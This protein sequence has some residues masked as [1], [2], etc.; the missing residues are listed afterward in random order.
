[1]EPF[2]TILYAVQ[3]DVLNLSLP[4]PD[5]VMEQAQDLVELVFESM[6]EGPNDVVLDL[7]GVGYINSSGISVI[8]RLNLE[9]NLRLVNPS[10]MVSEI[11]ELTGVLPF[12]PRFGSL[13]EAIASF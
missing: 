11:L 7:S 4:G 8:I 1:M 10:R 3:D 6:E 9:R 13:E 5:F 12:V 2:K